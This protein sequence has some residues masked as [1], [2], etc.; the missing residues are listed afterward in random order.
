VTFK[1]VD[2][3]A[4]IGGV[5]LGFDN[6]GF[7]TVFSNDFEQKCAFT[8]DLNFTS[9]KLTVG[10]IEDI[11]IKS[12]PEFNVLTAGFPCQPFSIAGHRKGFKDKN[13]GNLFWDI[14]KILKKRRPEII[15]LEN[16]KNLKGHDEGNTYQTIIHALTKLGYYTKDM[17]LNSMCYGNIPQNRERIYIVGFLNKKFW[18]KFAFPK[19]LELVVTVPSLLDAKVS[20]K[21]RYTK[22]YSIYNELRKAVKDTTAVYQWRRKYVR[23][24]KSGVCPTLTANMGMGGHNV[25][26]VKVG[27]TIRKL[28][29]RECA[30]I[31]GFPDTYILPSSSADSVLYKQVGNSVTVPVIQRIAEQIKKAVSN[32]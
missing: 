5:R 28:T 12:L 30:R 13:R 4:G 25:P 24:N 1:V 29:P 2:L 6:A 21:Y 26:I 16:V 20:T 31:Q 27:K 19:P 18:E 14:I 7:T 17:V 9:P 11:D 10:K 8:Y 15:F 32:E 22:K 3:F 23:K